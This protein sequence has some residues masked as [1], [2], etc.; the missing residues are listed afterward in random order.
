MAV[1]VNYWFRLQKVL[2]DCMQ[3]CLR[4]KTALTM[5]MFRVRPHCTCE[6]ERDIASSWVLLISSVLSTLP[7]GNDQR[8]AF[9][10]AQWVE[11]IKSHSITCYSIF[12]STLL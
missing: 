10:L 9:A 5:F 3:A 8:F 4:S 12:T 7:G 11:N 6:S 2:C 1:R